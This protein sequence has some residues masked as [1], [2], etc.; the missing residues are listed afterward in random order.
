[1]VEIS[2]AR[3]AGCRTMA[4]TTPSPTVV[5]S[6]ADSTGLASAVMDGAFCRRF[7]IPNTFSLAVRIGRAVLASRRLHQDPGEAVVQQSGG[8]RYIRGKVVDV[9]RRATRGFA[10]GRLVVEGLDDDAGRRVEIDFQ[11][12][13]L[14]IREGE[15]V[16]VTVPD[17]ITLVTT[18]EGEPITTELVRY[19]LRTDVLV[20]PCPDLLKTPV[21]LEV[22]GPGPSVTTS[23]TVR[24]SSDPLAR[25]RGVSLQN[26]VGGTGLI[27][28]C[29]VPSIR[30]HSN[31]RSIQWPKRLAR[32]WTDPVPSVANS[33]SRPPCVS[34]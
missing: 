18:D 15:E 26:A 13:N 33:R 31:R 12:E 10:K 30:K 16:P 17:L 14:V 3:S 19:G 24:W 5:R 27:R 9:E 8:R 2:M 21:A 6:V 11:N 29:P 4:D 7:I 34:M 22:V 1:M 23:I 32:R 20:I 25:G 28:V